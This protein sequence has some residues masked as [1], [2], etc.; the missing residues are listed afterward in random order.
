[1]KRSTIA[2]AVVILLPL[3]LSSH[4]VFASGLFDQD[5]DWVYKLSASW[6]CNLISANFN[7]DS[8][9]D[10]VLGDLSK[11]QIQTFIGNGDGSFDLF[12]SIPLTNPIW[13]ETS[14]VDLDGDQDVVVM[15]ENSLS[16]YTLL[17]DGI[18][19][20]S[21]PI[22]SN[23]DAGGENFVVALFDADTLPDIVLGNGP[24][25][26]Y[27]SHGNG[28]GTFEEAEK[29]YEEIC[30]ACALD[31][32]DL[33][34][35]GDLDIVLLAWE[36]LSVLFNDG[37]GTVTWGGYYGY[38]SG[39]GIPGGHITLAHLDN[40][41]F[42]DV[43]LTAGEGMGSNTVWTFLGNGDGSFDITG[44]GWIGGCAFNHVIS[45][46]FDLDGYNDAFFCGSEG[47]LITMLNSGN[48]LLIDDPLEFVIGAIPS[49]RQGAVADFD[50]DGD[51]DFAYVSG[52]VPNFYIHVHLNKLNPQ[53]IEGSE[54]TVNSIG[55]FA[56]P[57]P[58]SSSLGI[59]YSLPESGH[60]ELS[61]YDLSG[62]CMGLVESC[63]KTAGTHTTTWTPEESIPE[64]C[65]IVVLNTSED[66][67]VRRC[68]KL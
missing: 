23:I 6:W 64:G 67:I 19:N 59:T 28:D 43:A 50:N 39:P 25:N 5:P 1:M 24:G 46:D 4:S 57:S 12:Q 55:L 49:S 34:S 42:L 37:D 54:E 63:W 17:N 8:I 22:T 35:D 66:R 26:V 9:P 58:F 56:S 13:L 27:Y 7:T 62:R 10:M 68:V 31:I 29:I 18:G 20:L 3:I 15:R 47:L 33:D 36:R 16:I 61:I 52:N 51:F 38:Y 30:G 60:V 48:G 32:A 65:Y 41:E 40:D 45:V 44:S 14:D 53:G 2:G 11:D 21:T